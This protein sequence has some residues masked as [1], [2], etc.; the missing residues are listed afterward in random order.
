MKQKGIDIV[1][2]AI[3]QMWDNINSKEENPIAR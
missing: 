3:N 1:L 2:V